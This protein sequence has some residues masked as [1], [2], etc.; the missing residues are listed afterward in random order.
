MAKKESSVRGHSRA[1]AVGFKRSIFGGPV[2]ECLGDSVVS[3]TCSF[4]HADTV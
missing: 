1:L 2:R 4:I 3:R